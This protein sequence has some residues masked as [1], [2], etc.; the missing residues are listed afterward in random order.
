MQI[1]NLMADQ[2]KLVY[3]LTRQPDFEGTHY[4]ICR[5]G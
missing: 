1:R 2:L 4:G 3:E 5:T